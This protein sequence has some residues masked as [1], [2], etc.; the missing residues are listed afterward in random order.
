[1]LSHIYW[2]CNKT[3]TEILKENHERGSRQASSE[4]RRVERF[5]KLKYDDG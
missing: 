3:F 2:I 1:M 5:A 4:V